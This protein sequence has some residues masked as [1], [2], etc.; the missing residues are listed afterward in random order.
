MILASIA[1]PHLR[2]PV[3]RTFNEIIIDTPGLVGW[4]KADETSGTTMVDSS[5]NGNDA[6]Y[7]GSVTLNQT[8]LRDGSTACIQM[9]ANGRAATRSNSGVSVGTTSGSSATWAC[10]LKNSGGGS[11]LR[12]AFGY[13]PDNL[14]QENGPC[15][16]YGSGVAGIS[17]G[18]AYGGTD[19]VVT[20]FQSPNSTS[21][22]VVFVAMVKSGTT[23]T[24]YE[25]GTSVNSL[26]TA[27]SAGV[28]STLDF[29]GVPNFPASD[30][31]IGYGSDF[32]IYNTALTAAQL[33][34]M[35]QA[36]GL[37]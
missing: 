20:R 26:T 36:A 5:P 27:F 1:R 32:M 33:L 11:V 19:S 28:Y 29:L 34:S 18:H 37:A 35:A 25:N 4:W 6:T 13:G 30:G 10:I 31:F 8:P 2:V 14:A 24:L 9:T 22:S 23:W 21:G 16:G 17:T 12:K 7:S 3:T 15:I